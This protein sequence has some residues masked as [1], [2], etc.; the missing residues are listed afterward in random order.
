MFQQI[1]ENLI[2]EQFW[3]STSAR[4]HKIFSKIFFFSGYEK[5]FWTKDWT[6][7]YQLMWNRVF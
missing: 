1:S 6:S 4:P 5:Q 7:V 2:L 3:T